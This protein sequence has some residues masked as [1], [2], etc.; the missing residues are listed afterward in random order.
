[1]NSCSESK[2]L[3]SVCLCVCRF[4]RRQKRRERCRVPEPGVGL[5]TPLQQL[6]SDACFL[7]RSC[8]RYRSSSPRSAANTSWPHDNGVQEEEAAEAAATGQLV[9]TARRQHKQNVCGSRRG[10]TRDTP[11]PV[12]CP[13]APLQEDRNQG[14]RNGAEQQCFH[15]TSSAHFSFSSVHITCVLWT[16]YQHLVLFICVNITFLV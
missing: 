13:T 15:S 16:L 2:P 8:P 14:Q 11:G 10:W 4:H 9:P 6:Q 7:R 3:T 5:V 1:M 12:V